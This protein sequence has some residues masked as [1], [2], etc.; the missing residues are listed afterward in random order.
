MYARHDL[1]PQRDGRVR[2]GFGQHDLLGVIIAAPHNAGVIRRVARKPPVKVARGR[3]GLAGHGH[4]VQLRRRAGAVADGVL[5]H[6]GDI[7]RRHILH[8]DVGILRIVQN[9]LL[10]SRVGHAGIGA[11]LAVDALVGKGRIRRRHRAHAHAVRQAAHRHWREVHVGEHLALGV[12]IIRYQ[13]TQPHLVLGKGVAVFRRHLGHE[14]DGDRIVGMADRLVD[15]HQPAVDV[16]G[17]FR[18]AG[19]VGKGIGRVVIDRGGR[20]EPQL[21][22]GGVDRHRL[23][24]GAR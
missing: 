23:D 13:R 16:V 9:D 8:G 7:P 22:R 12:Y 11:R 2:R 15:R 24:G 5:Q 3:A 18:P 10:A 20:D 19:A 14:L 1:L 4:A 6:I 21:D 17:I